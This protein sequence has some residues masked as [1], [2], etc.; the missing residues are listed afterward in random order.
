MSAPVH[1]V[2][3]LTHG[4]EQVVGVL[5]SARWGERKGAALQ[6]GT[7]VVSRTERPDGSVELVLSRELPKGGPSFLQK[8]LPRDGRVVQTD[9][10]GPAQDGVRRGTWK[11]EIP[12]APARLAGSLLLEP[13]GADASRYTIQGQADVPIPLVGGKAERFI[14]E[15]VVALSA[16]EAE[17]LRD[18]L[19]EG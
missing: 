6:D 12:G 5:T 15:M 16:R 1:H 9:D 14:A 4:V 7:R 8:F 2:V 18:A 13:A 10:W 19:G 11:V 17:V 3:D